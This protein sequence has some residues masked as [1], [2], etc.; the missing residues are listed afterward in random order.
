MHQILDSVDICS[1]HSFGKNVRS[2]RNSVSTPIKASDPSSAPSLVSCS[3][4]SIQIA[5]GIGLIRVYNLS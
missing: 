5:S 3:S 4:L 2:R 1:R